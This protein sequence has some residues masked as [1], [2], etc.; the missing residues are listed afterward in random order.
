MIGF[1]F[2]LNKRG[3][4]VQR[5]DVE[6]SVVSANNINH[7]YHYHNENK[8]KHVRLSSKSFN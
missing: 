4:E 7:H 6:R 2:I 3:G 8:T 5:V 1:N